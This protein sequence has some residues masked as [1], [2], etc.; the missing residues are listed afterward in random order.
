MDEFQEIFRFQLTSYFFWSITT[1]CSS[2]LSIQ[3]EMVKYLYC[4]H[5]FLISMHFIY[6][7]SLIQSHNQGNVVAFV[8]PMFIILW[9]F[10]Q[11]FLFCNLAEN[12]TI[13]YEELEDTIYQCDWYLF[14]ADVQKIL[15]TIIMCAQDPVIIKGFGVLCTR[16]V[17]KKVNFQI[18]NYFNL[19]GITLL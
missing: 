1:I 14:S 9:S 15:P 12:V 4:F 11:I 19:F 3:M 10:G 18:K 8:K 7:C 17:F 5:S 16:E 2:L 6:F 13:Q